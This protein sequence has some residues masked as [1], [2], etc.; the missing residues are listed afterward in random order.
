MDGSQGW[1]QAPMK[2]GS[3]RLLKELPSPPPPRTQ[4]RFAESTSY[5]CSERQDFK[6]FIFWIEESFQSVSVGG[7]CKDKRKF[8][9]VSCLF[10]NDIFTLWVSLANTSQRQHNE[11][12]VLRWNTACLSLWRKLSSMS[13]ILGDALSPQDWTVQ[14]ILSY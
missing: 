12:R 14:H 9:H 2:T 3:P 6:V 11:V 10:H 8:G 5:K 13:L 7:V 1:Q 4:H